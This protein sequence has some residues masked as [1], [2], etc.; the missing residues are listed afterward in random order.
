[1]L[2]ARLKGEPNVAVRSL[3]AGCVQAPFQN[4]CDGA[5]PTV[6]VTAPVEPELV[7]RVPSPVK[8]LTLELEPPQVAPAS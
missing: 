3:S 8:E 6:K 1:V 5:E 4:L 7:I 2:V